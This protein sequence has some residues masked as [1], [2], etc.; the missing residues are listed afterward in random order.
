MKNEKTWKTKEVVVAA[1]VSVVIGILFILMDL[2]YMPLAAVLGAVFMEILFWRLY[3]F[4]NF[5]CLYH[6]KTGV[7]AVWS[8]CRRWR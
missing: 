1:M 7:R 4:S 3:A 8:H 5:T 6:A 2:A